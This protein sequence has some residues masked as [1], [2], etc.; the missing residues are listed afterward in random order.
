MK[1]FEFCGNS[2]G[3]HGGQFDKKVKFGATCYGKKPFGM[4]VREKEAKC[5][6]AKKSI[7]QEEEEKK[8]KKEKE[9]K[10]GKSPTD[11]IYPFNNDTWYTQ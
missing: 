6:K 5:E 2:G 11:I 7:L 3:L 8:Q 10:C 9:K 1:G 4:S